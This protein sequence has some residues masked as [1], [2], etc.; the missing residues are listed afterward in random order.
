MNTEAKAEN[1]P[2]CHDLV[3]FPYKINI[4]LGRGGACL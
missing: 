4:K 2:Q 1:A 3:P